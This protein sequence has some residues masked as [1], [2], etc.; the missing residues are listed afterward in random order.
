MEKAGP[1]RLRPIL[2][3]ATATLMAAIPPALGLGPGSEI[4]MPMAIG[5]IGGLVLSTA[6][7]L[8]VVPAFYVIADKLAIRKKKPAEEMAPAPEGTQNG[9]AA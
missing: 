8:V 7:S 9:A 3:T 1:I 5:V 2:M 6:L 4:R